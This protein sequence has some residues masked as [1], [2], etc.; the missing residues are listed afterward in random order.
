VGR[1]LYVADGDGGWWCWMSL[2]PAWRAVGQVD[3]SG[4]AYGVCVMDGYAYVADGVSGLQVVAL[5]DL[6]PRP[7]LRPRTP[8]RQRPLSPTRPPRRLRLRPP[9]RQRGRR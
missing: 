2:L 5:A 8:T 6:R 4:H 1:A 3:T 9:P 7:R